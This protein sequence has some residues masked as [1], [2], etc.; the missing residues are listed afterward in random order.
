MADTEFIISGL[1]TLDE[2]ELREALPEGQVD[3][4]RSTVP[5]GTLAEP[6][7][8]TAIVTL[9]SI[10][11]AGLSAWLSKARRRRVSKFRYKVRKADGETVDVELD[12]DESS[13]D[14]VKASVMAQL[15][16]WVSPS[17]TAAGK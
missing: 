1:T 14:A 13:E 16:K 8:I 15:S 3:T 7:T 6:A 2:E 5:E 12:L 9:G 11:L 10:A 4:V 17:P